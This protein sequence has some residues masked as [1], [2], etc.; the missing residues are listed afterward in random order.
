MR[1]MAIKLWGK[2]D[3]DRCKEKLAGLASYDIEEIGLFSK[4]QSAEIITGNKRER[5]L[6]LFEILES[7]VVI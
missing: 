5:A 2:F 6:K 1:S 4:A 3:R 7:K